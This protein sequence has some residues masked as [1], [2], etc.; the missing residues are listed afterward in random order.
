MKRTALFGTALLLAGLTSPLSVTSAAAQEAIPG[1]DLE[2]NFPDAMP[3]QARDAM[4]E[5]EKILAATVGSVVPIVIDIKWEAQGE[6]TL[7]FAGPTT[8]FTTE[9]N[10]V[11]PIA[12]ANALAGKD[13]APEQSDVETT[14]NLEFAWDY[15]LGSTHPTQ[16]D[17][18]GT[19]VHELLHGMG[20]PGAQSNFCE[21][22][23]C[24]LRNDTGAL[25]IWSSFLALGDGTRLSE[26][27]DRS[28]E[29]N[30]A[31]V[32]GDVFWDGPRAIAV[33]A[34]RPDVCGEH[35]NEACVDRPVIHAPNPYAQGSSMSHLD[36]ATYRGGTADAQM[37][38]DGQKG[39]LAQKMG[40][41]AHA[42]LLDVGWPDSPSDDPTGDET[43]YGDDWT[44]LDEATPTLAAV[45]VSRMRFPTGNT[46]PIAI[47]SRD[48]KFADALSATG[49]TR[50]GP[51]LLTPSGSLDADVRTELGR[52][53]RDD[54]TVYIVGGPNAIAPEIEEEL[55]QEY[56]VVRLSGT[57]RFQTSAAI[58]YATY[59]LS[60]IPS[61]VLVARGYGP[62][63]AE[64]G[65]AAWADSISA[66]AAA[67]FL[68]APLL[69]VGTDSVDEVTAEAANYFTE[70]QLG[71][72]VLGGPGAV[73]E[74][75]YDFIGA[76]QRVAGNSRETTAVAIARELMQTSPS[77][78]SRGYIIVN[79]RDQAGWAWGLAAAG[80]AGDAHAAIL[81][82]DTAVSEA[83][84]AEVR[85]CGETA[86][87]LVIA[88]NTD[89]ISAS[90]FDQLEAQ[91][92][93][94]C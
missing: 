32:S 20:L 64:N 50:Y 19:M 31:H 72:V 27:E 59:D 60:P 88:G 74:R 68:G 49:L 29:M 69:L 18:I 91:D 45:T 77:Q 89:V 11:M 14:I 13:L 35:R 36:E 24:S 41:I 63:G 7:A 43:F 4:L 8:F 90:V 15:H 17:F 62:A 42:M 30:A 34:A 73:S 48:D 22:E 5:V 94:D 39:E 56:T 80:L 84:L 71:L 38:P 33:A 54:A 87:E 93:A 78:A 25:D 82:V 65:S 51:L 2:F 67:S 1:V 10:V 28:P 57:D 58:A 46:A 3:Q 61:Y 76:S 6:E 92:G 9:D 81:L 79:A 85:N 52:V 70:Q 47:L 16:F 23:A 75:V 83:T 66:A 26:F 21:E 37:S 44:R 86:V 53:L 40:P 12:L 55:A